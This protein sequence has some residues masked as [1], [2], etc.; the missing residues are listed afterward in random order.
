MLTVTSEMDDKLKAMEAEQADELKQL[1]ANQ[2]QPISADRPA[3]EAE[4]K[5]EPVPP[6][7][8]TS[9]DADKKEVD[10]AIADAEK[11]GHELKKDEQGKY[12]RDEKGKFVKQPKAPVQDPAVS[13]VYE[14]IKGWKQEQLNALLDKFFPNASKYAK[15]NARKDT[16]WKALNEEKAKF[17]TERKA[18]QDS[19][20]EAK[21]RFQA[22]VDA[23][24]EE[25]AQ[26]R[27][28]ADKYEAWSKA[29]AQKADDLNAAAKKAEDAGEFDKAEALKAQAAEA[30]GL[31][32]RAK[33]MAEDVR[34]NPPQDD[35]ARQEK[36]VADQRTWINKAAQ[37]FPEFGKK[38]SEVQ[39][40]AAEYYRQMTAQIP[41]LNKLPGFVYFCA[42]RA[43]LM[44]KANSGKAA[45][46]RVSALE[47][48]NGELQAKV[49]E[50]DALTNPT[51]QGGVARVTSGG[52]PKTDDQEY[53]ELRQM[54]ANLPR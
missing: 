18:F 41:A 29:E 38:D 21:A 30:S 49:K 53:E 33:D 43:D 50:L 12:L 14:Q 51:P 10:D 47:K 2:E 35:K 26:A 5:P 19:V 24:K 39:K 8:E 9:S 42:E 27:P 32:K 37:D 3:P 34:K 15:E 4:V 23:F 22:D 17:E 48:E 44:L 54:A 28:N 20:T 7:P 36:F 1:D 40:G 16:S 46:E 11:T 52:G 6:K 45:S 31:S 13:G 25:Q